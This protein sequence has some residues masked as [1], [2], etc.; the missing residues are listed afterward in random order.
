M[1]GACAI[2]SSVV[3][4][5]LSYKVVQIWPGLICTNV[6]TNQSRSYLNHLVFSPLYSHKRQDFQKKKKLLNIK[7]VFW[8]SAQ[9]SAESFLIL[10]R[11]Q[12]DPIK[13]VYWS[14]CKVP[15]ILQILMQL[16][17]ARKIF[18]KYWYQILWKS[19]WKSIQWESSCSVRTDGQTWRS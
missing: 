1:Q 15:V 12:R 4:P 14:S 3:S 16:E 9:I 6:H 13:T 2:L 19:I 7:C 11:I 18:E 5:S 10:R 17:F 8:F